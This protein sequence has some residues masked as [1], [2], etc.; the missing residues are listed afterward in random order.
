MEERLCEFSLRTMTIGHTSNGNVCKSISLHCYRHFSTGIQCTDNIGLSRCHSE[1]NAHVTTA[2]TEEVRKLPREGDEGDFPLQKKVEGRIFSIGFCL[3]S[4]DR[5]RP[6]TMPRPDISDLASQ[7]HE[8]PAL[9]AP[10]N[11]CVLPKF[12]TPYS[13]DR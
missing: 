2:V 10:C 5:A 3:D 12:L 13:S 7:P 6:R 11:L 9:T 1:G 4:P 8:C